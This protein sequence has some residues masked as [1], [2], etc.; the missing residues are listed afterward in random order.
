M[1]LSKTFRLKESR[2]LQVR[3]DAFNAL[4]HVNDSNPNSNIT[5]AGF[6]Q[7][8]GVGASRTAQIGARFTF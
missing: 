5:S 7:I 2:R 4:N 6:G 1:S 8:S 3:A